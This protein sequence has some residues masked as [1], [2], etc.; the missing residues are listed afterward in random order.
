MRKKDIDGNYV[1]RSKANYQSVR[2][3]VEGQYQ[4][5]SSLI[6]FLDGNKKD[7][8]KADGKEYCL[9]ADGYKWLNYILD[10]E[11]WCL[12]AMYNN[13]GEIV[14]WYFDITKSNFI[15]EN[16]NPCIDDLYLDIVLFPSGET[17]ILDEDELLDAL[18]NGEITKL[19]YD[20]AYQILNKIIK[21][22]LVDVAFISSLSQLLLSEYV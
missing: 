11:N 18:N 10:N 7:I 8:V 12:T 2:K 6:T 19:E 16:G 4:G 21:S 14:E 20:F 17:L 15:D 1:K 5:Y 13:Q 22:E 9:A 3:K